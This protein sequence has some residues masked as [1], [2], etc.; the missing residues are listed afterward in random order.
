M[1]I[2]KDWSD[3]TGRIFGGTER[4]VEQLP[5]AVAHFLPPDQQ[6]QGEIRCGTSRQRPALARAA[7]LEVFNEI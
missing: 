4:V 6:P 3:A 1:A 7:Q 5:V 2:K